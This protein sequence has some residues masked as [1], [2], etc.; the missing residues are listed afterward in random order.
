MLEVDKVYCGTSQIN[1]G[2]GPGLYRYATGQGKVSSDT[3]VV[4]S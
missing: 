4:I 1:P 3:T 2:T